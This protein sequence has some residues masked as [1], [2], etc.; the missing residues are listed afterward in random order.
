[1]TGVRRVLVVSRHPYPLAPTLRRNLMQLVAWRLAVDVV[2]LT[3]GFR[4][5]APVA[6]Q[7]GLRLYG[8]PSRTHRTH[9]LWYPLHYVTFF[10]WALVVVSL[11]SL[12]RR[13]DVIEVDNTPDF[14]VFTTV[15]ARLRGTRIVL[16]ALELM[17]ELTAARLRLDSRALTV[18]VATSLE[19]AAMAWVD[20][21]ITVSEL[22]RRI[23]LGRGL[24]SEKVTVVP[25]S[26]PLAGLRTAS[27]T[28]PP[29]LV[30]QTTLIERYGVHIAIRALA[31]LASEW[32]GLTLRVLGQG[33]SEPMLVELTNRLGLQDRVLFS[34]GYLPW[35][36]MMDQVGQATLGIVPLL[37]DGY[38]DLCLPNKLL[39]FVAL[40]IP[41]VCARLRAIEEQFPEDCLAYFDPGDDAGLAAQ[42]SRLL[43]NPQAAQRQAG[44]AR[45]A[46][47][48]L[49]WESVSGR[50]QDALGLSA[51]KPV[52][53]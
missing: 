38:G 7:P 5:A 19:R 25:N 51:R 35:R 18:R 40:G 33:E 28:Q 52:E 13:Y 23:L 46:M 9:V 20:H 16:F 32:P 3:P 4:W 11:L 53:V 2:C 22:C 21:V 17:P 43:A 39:E 26:H 34:H 37:A 6:D 8:I 12:F 29:F 14:L 31:R 47:S 42:V 30:I 44:L 49:R 45:A 41:V 15:L 24:Q 27:P 10:L 36:E 1:M 50:Y 48:D